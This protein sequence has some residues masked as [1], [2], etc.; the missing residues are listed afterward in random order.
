[1]GE[2]CVFH[3]ILARYSRLKSTRAARETKRA[4]PYPSRRGAPRTLAPLRLA[5]CWGRGQKRVRGLAGRKRALAVEFCAGWLLCLLRAM[6]GKVLEKDELLR[7]LRNNRRRFQRHMQQ[8]IAKYNRPFEDDPLVH[9]ATL[10]YETPQGLRIWGG[11]LIKERNK[12][13]IQAFTVVSGNRIDGSMQATAQ[14]HELPSHCSQVPKADSENSDSDT[15]LNQED[16]VAWTLTPAVPQSP[17]KNELRRK[18]LT[19]VDILLQD[20]GYFERVDNTA[21]KDACMTLFPSLASPTTSA[22]GSCGSVSGKSPG[23]PAKPTSSPRERD[24]SCPSSIDMAIVPRNDSLL[25]PGIS[26]SSLLSSE[27]FEDDDICNVTI[28]DLYSGMLH[29]MSRLLSAKPSSII[30]TKISILQNWNSRRR[31]RCRSRMNNTYCKRGRHYQR[32]SKER[33]LPCSEPVKDIRALRDYKN[34]LDVSCHKTSLKLEN[35]FPEV[36]KPQ[37]HKLDPSWKEL[38]VMP[39]KYSSSTYFSPSVMHNLDQE[40]RLM[41]LKWLI[42]PVK[43]GSRPRI[44][45]GPG[46]NRQ[47]EIEIRFDKL[48]QKYCLSPRN[49][50]HL[51]GPPDS[52]ALDVYRGGPGVP[53][54]LER[55][56]LSLPLRRGKAKRLSEVFENLGSRSVSKCLPKSDSFLSVSEADPTQNPDH[57]QWTSGL[58][59]QENNSRVFRKSVSPSKTISVPRIG[60]L[61]CGRNHYDEIKE[62]FDKLHQ[63]YYPRLPQQTKAPVCIEVSPDAASVEV[64]DQTEVSLGKLNPDSHFQNCQKLSPPL[65]YIKSPLGSP[66]IEAHSSR[67]VAC[68]TRRDHQYPAKRRRL[69]DPQGCGYLANSQD[70][71]SGVDRAI[72]RPGEQGSSSQPNSEEKKVCLFVECEDLCE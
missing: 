37:I 25:L 55:H 13:Q 20:P 67:C 12:G 68:A 29:S 21:G 28:S 54:S 47:R 66:A 51:A 26:S 27:S 57:S 9:M 64:Q 15:T 31:H 60:P 71:S 23:D 16:P 8:L 49:H 42:S 17:L 38:K 11:R 61:V 58:H 43:I 33:I 72:L 41:M 40:N 1:M 52:R 70:A 69:S 63:K 14:G 3:R 6:A 22:P 59:F 32:S 4:L 50:S 18:Y 44:L 62:K 53:L 24:P 2:W 36:N 5:R 19:Q 34:L 56:R 46:E 39:Q 48:H 7:K 65:E 10:T 35:V 30:S 45:Q